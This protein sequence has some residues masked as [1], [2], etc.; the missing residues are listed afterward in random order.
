MDYQPQKHQRG[1]ETHGIFILN[2][3]QKTVIC[4]QKCNYPLNGNGNLICGYSVGLFLLSFLLSTLLNLFHLIFAQISPPC[5]YSPPSLTLLFLSS[6]YKSLPA[7]NAG[8]AARPCSVHKLHPVPVSHSWGH[9]LLH[10]QSFVSGLHGEPDTGPAGL[11]WCWLH[12]SASLPHQY[13]DVPGHESQVR[14]QPIGFRLKYLL[15]ALS[16]VSQ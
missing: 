2:G 14:N 1:F 4:R 12:H 10:F 13:R 6:D 9:R 8:A 15:D 3:D 11:S 16:Y 7:S 5:L